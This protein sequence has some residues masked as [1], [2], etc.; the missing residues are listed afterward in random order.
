M[1]KARYQMALWVLVLTIHLMNVDHIEHH[2]TDVRVGVP[3]F[4]PDTR[5]E[6]AAIE[7][8]VNDIIAEEEAMNLD[9]QREQ[10]IQD[11]PDPV[12]QEPVDP[13]NILRWPTQNPVPVNE[14]TTDGYVAMAFPCLFPFG[15]ADIR[16]QANRQESLGIAEYFSA[17]IEYKDGRFGNH[18]RCNIWNLCG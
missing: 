5:T 13:E 1:P 7:A 15:K 3:L 17:L 11:H 4:S 9:I 8:V 18:N 6:D 16:Y 12:N 2:T 10:G 14:Y